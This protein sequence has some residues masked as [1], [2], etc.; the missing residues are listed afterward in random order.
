MKIARLMCLLVSIAAA[1]PGQKKPDE[2][3]LD[4]QVLELKAKQ[5]QRQL[6]LDGR[7]RAVAPKSIRGLTIFFDFLSDDGTVLASEKTKVDEELLAPGR[8]LHPR[9]YRY[10]PP[11]RGR[12]VARR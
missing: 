11:R 9:R 6:A 12:E 1:V 7:V 2:K 4:V 10:P 8:I 3:K 5:S